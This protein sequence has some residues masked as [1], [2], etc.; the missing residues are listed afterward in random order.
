MLKLLIISVSAWFSFICVGQTDSSRMVNNALLGLKL[1]YNSSL[2]YPGLSAGIEFPV[3][4]VSVAKTNK[5]LVEKAITRSRFISGNMNWYHH[6]GFH[7]NVYL[8]TEWVMRRTKPGGF[9]S[10]FSSGL[11]FSRTFVGGTTYRVAADGIVSIE[12]LRGYNYAMIT[13]GGGIGYDLQQKNQLPLSLFGK[14][15]LFSMF[16]YNSTIYLRPAFE[17]G[18]RF[19]TGCFIFNRFKKISVTK[20]KSK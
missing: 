1:S 4:I 7:D 2:I 14:M 17:L 15:N 16:P 6:P 19:N 3:K 9:F 12:K 5:A 20:T 8:T 13:A 18:L 11:G 10:E